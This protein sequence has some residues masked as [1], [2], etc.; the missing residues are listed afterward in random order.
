MSSCTLLAILSYTSVVSFGHEFHRGLDLLWS[1]NSGETAGYHKMIQTYSM[2]IKRDCW[3][4]LLSHLSSMEKSVTNNSEANPYCTMIT[5][6]ICPIFGG[7][8]S[9]FWGVNKLIFAWVILSHG[10]CQAIYCLLAYWGDKY[11]L[12]RGSRRLQHDFDFERSSRK[13]QMCSFMRHL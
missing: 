2:C 1:E 13:F 8:R 11:T 10:P 3:G 6:H 4:R 5:V 12:L 9:S 7:V